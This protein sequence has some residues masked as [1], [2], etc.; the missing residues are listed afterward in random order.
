MFHCTALSCFLSSLFLKAFPE[1]AKIPLKEPEKKQK[2]QNFSFSGAESKIWHRLDHLRG[3]KRRRVIKNKQHPVK[4]GILG[5]MA[6]RLK[7]KLI[8]KEKAVD[9]G[10]LLDL[11]G[12]DKYNF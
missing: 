2:K 11:Y 3:F 4:I 8:E 12:L 1:T 9:V 7:E 6:E 10:V 5:C